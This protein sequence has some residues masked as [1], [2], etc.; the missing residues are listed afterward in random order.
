MLTRYTYRKL[1]WIDLE[2]PTPGEVR[3]LMEEYKIHPLVGEEL[4]GPTVRPKVDLYD[5]C[6]YLILH[7]PTVTHSHNGETEQEVDFIVGKDFLITVRYDTIDSLREFAKVFEMNSVLDKSNLGDHAG[8][9]FF[10]IMRE[11]YK[12]LGAELGTVTSRLKRI[13][14]GIFNGNE[15]RMV[16]QISETNKLLLDFR[17]SIRFHKDVLESFEAAGKRFFEEKFHYYLRSL[18]GEYY[19]VY[20]LLENQKETLVDLRETNDSL[21]TTKTNETMKALTIIAFLVLPIQ[22]IT[23]VFSME[24]WLPV[25][26]APEDFLAVLAIMALLVALALIF[27]KSKRWI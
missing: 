14:D 8:Y 4:L 9:L 13:E 11:L 1:T 22:L 23:Q 26:S 5:N 10:Y 7:F 12:N 20:N 27:L 21:L 17:E 25:G 18:I 16:R 24:T 6:I 2:N 19:K 3:G 15:G